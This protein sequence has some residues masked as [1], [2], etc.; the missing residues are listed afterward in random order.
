MNFYESIADYYDQVFPLNKAQLGFV[1]NSFDKVDELSLLDIGCGT[2]DLSF[3]LSKIFSEVTAIDLD[4]AMLKKAQEK[5]GK[6]LK[7]Q[8]LNMLSIE[9][10]FGEKSF[11]AITCFG[12]TLVH[13]EGPGQILDFFKQVRKILKNGGK[14]LFQIINYDRIIDNQVKAL[15]T[16]ENKKIKFVRNYNY[17]ASKNIID[18]NTTLTVKETNKQLSNTIQLYPLLNAELINLLNEA[19]FDHVFFFKNFK[20]DVIDPNSLPLVVEA[21]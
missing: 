3:E 14:L 9:K 21:Y 7:F 17:N 6:S 18:F 15:P 19:G 10:E 16:I 2:G 12:N 8:E 13:L 20:R 4:S 11:D 5:F 1:K